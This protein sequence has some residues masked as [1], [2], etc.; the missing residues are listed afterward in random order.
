MKKETN[1]KRPMKKI[2]NKVTT[3][4]VEEVI[5]PQPVIITP[6][7]VIVST[8]LTGVGDVIAKVTTFF[9]VEPCA[10]CLMRKAKLNKMFSFLRS[11]QRDLTADE[12]KYVYE[13]ERTKYVPDGNAFV[14]LFNE[15]YGTKQKPCNCPGIYKDILEK[16][17][18]QIKY[19]EII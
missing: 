8:P 18:M 14:A 2:V 17:V 13:I 12:I 10:D 5:N 11:V 9:G 15:I 3:P 19:Q 16:M 7:D 1:N 4:L 6:D